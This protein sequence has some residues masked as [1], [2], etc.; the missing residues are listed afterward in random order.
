MTRKVQTGLLCA[1]VLLS[2]LTERH[3]LV[4]SW[5]LSFDLRGTPVE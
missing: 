3:L 2:G 1:E 5:H 4:S